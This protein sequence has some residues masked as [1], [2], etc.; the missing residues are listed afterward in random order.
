MGTLIAAILGVL[1]IGAGGSAGITKDYLKRLAAAGVS[2][3]VIVAYVQ[4]YG[5]PPRLSADDLIELKNAGISNY[6]LERVASA[7]ATDRSQ[8]APAAPIPPAVER[9]VTVVTGPPVVPAPVIWYY[10]WG[11]WRSCAPCL[12][13]AVR[14]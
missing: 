11:P 7:P 2:D 3:G 12:R 6:V 8:I 5:P 14:W 13:F 4:S 10:P 9:R 1:A